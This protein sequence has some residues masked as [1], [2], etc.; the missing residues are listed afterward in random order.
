MI[1]FVKQVKMEQQIAQL[2]Q[3]LADREDQ[4]A[5]LRL[6]AGGASQAVQTAPLNS[7]SKKEKK[8]LDG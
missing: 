6:E 2:Q 8:S 7:L 5:Q 4:I 1:I 3:A